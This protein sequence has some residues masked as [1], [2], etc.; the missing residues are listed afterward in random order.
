METKITTAEKVKDPKRVAQ[1]KRFAAIPEKR[2]HGK[3]RNV[4]NNASPKFHPTCYLF[5]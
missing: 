2:K 1:G 4:K 3:R 5:P